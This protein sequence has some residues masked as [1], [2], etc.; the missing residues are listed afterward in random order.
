[1]AALGVQQEVL[2][3]ERRDLFKDIKPYYGS[4]ELY[5]V[6]ESVPTLFSLSVKFVLE[7]ELDCRSIPPTLLTK[8]HHCQQQQLYKGPKIIKCSGCSKFYSK[9]QKFLDH[10]CE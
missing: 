2:G 7:R 9:Q 1:M 3:R 4:R 6:R 8:L 10:I 5:E